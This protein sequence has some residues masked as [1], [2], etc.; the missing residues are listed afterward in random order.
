MEADVLL[1]LLLGGGFL[2]G[3]FRGVVRMFIAIGAWAFS[4]LLASHLRLPVGDFL[5]RTDVQFSPS[6]ATMVSFAAIFAALLVTS[7]VLIMVS[8]APTQLSRHALVDDLLGGLL[9][10]V[11]ALLLMAS[12]IVIL[13]THYAI[14][15]PAP[16]RDIP[17]LTSLHQLLRSSAVAGAVRDTVVPVLGFVFGPLLPAEVRAVMT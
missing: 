5:F 15:A 6:Y 8:R 16:G 11:A 7:V 4:F 1:I 17:L 13:D 10:V 3:F 14:E 9:G 12:I 2:L